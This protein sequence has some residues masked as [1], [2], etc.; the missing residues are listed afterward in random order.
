MA[1]TID[2]MKSLEQNER[3]KEMKVTLV[4]YTGLGAANA[5]QWAAAQLIFA[6]KTRLE[7]KP[8]LLREIYEDWSPLKVRRE[9]EAIAKTIPSSWEFVRYTAFIGGVSRAF[10]HQLVRT[11]TASYAQQS[12]RVVDVSEGFEYATGPTVESAAAQVKAV[13]HHQM[14]M[15]GDAYKELIEEGVS[16]EDARG[17]LPTN[18]KTNIVMSLNLRTLVEMFRSRSSPRVQ[19]EYRDFIG[20]LSSRVIEI[21]PW[22]EI[23]IRRGKLNVVKDLEGIFKEHIKDEDARVSAWRAIDELRGQE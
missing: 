6:K 19:D 17:L 18:I 16:P 4:D 12:L 11:R 9:L 22:A 10:T 7:M 5:G 20:L 13:Y 21:H 23:F 3:D 1:F 15:I 14:D 8:S 2:F